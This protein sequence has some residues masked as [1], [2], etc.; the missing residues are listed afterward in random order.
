MLTVSRSDGYH[1]GDL[2]RALLDAAAEL[3]EQRGVEGLTLREV[4]RR[5][6][7]SH[8]AT[9]HHFVDRAALIAALVESGFRQLTLAMQTAAAAVGGGV[10]GSTLDRLRAIGVAYVVFATQHPALFR[11]LCRPELFAASDDG[12]SEA[13]SEA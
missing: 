4:A 10:P 12:L 6:G 1:H 3:L 2:R 8:A 5:A 11:L 7:V 13:G 9:Y